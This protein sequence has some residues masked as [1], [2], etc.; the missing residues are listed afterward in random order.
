MK[1]LIIF[2]L[3]NTFYDYDKSHYPALKKVY[4]KQK[5]YKNYQEF[6]SNYEEIKQSIHEVLD[7]SPSKH[8]KLIYFKNLF[9]NKLEIKEIR[10]LETIYWDEFIKNT[11][12]DKLS[13][14]ILKQNKNENNVYFLFTNQNLYIQLRKIEKWKLNFFDR[15]LTSEEVGHEK[16]TD[17]FFNYAENYVNDKYNSGYSIIAIGDSYENDIEYW[18]KKYDANCYLIDNTREETVVEDNINKTNFKK[19]ILDIFDQ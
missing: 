5:I 9:W 12:I 11:E 15:V 17:K 18:Q 14:E 4:K 10:E 3:D 8:S 2:D 19:A 6:F 7:E 1:R 13:I 16:P